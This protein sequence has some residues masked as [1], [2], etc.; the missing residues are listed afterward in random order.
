[1]NILLGA[2]GSVSAYRA[3]DLSRELM[4]QGHTVRVCLTDAAQNFVSAVLFETLTGEPCLIDTFEEPTTGRMAHID[5]ARQAD[6]IV[7]APATAN[8]INKLANGL[9]DDMLS[10]LALVTTRPMIICPAMNPQMYA[11]ET[12]QTSLRHLI[13][14]GA[15]VIEP[16]EGDVASGETGVGKLASIERIVECV[17]EVLFTSQALSG[18]KILITSGP[19]QEPIDSVR[20]ISNHSSGKMG[21]AVA[22][23]ALQMGAE[24]TVIAGPQSEPLP[25]GA[26][27]HSVTTA[28]QMHDQAVKLAPSFDWVIAVAAVADYRMATPIPGKMRRTEDSLTLELVVN[29][30]VIAAVAKVAPNAL[31]VGFA[32]E[33]TSETSV[34]Q[35]KIKRKGLF[36]IAANDISNDATTFGSTQNQ[37]K[38]LFSDGS[39][40]ESGLRS[41]FQCSI[42]LLAKIIDKCANRS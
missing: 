9:A 35:E 31:L 20:F 18:K 14:R 6:V 19:T 17:E 34:A 25:I 26:K 24:V 39:S 4:R 8:T 7:I 1:M 36:A 10:T 42:W 27:V 3:A 41:K 2:S 28:Q 22:K 11:H 40:A 13:S 5:W 16:T 32:A 15:T 23:A 29:P 38:L 37:L 33:P 21:S 30:D 12:V